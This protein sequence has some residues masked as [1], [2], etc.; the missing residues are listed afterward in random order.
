MLSITHPITIRAIIMEWWV[1]IRLKKRTAMIRRSKQLGKKEKEGSMT[2][3]MTARKKNTRIEKI[4]FM[5]EPSYLHPL[6]Y[7]FK[8][9]TSSIFS[10]STLVSMV[11]SWKRWDWSFVTISTRP[12]MSPFGK[13]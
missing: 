3:C 12:I 13:T 4:A 8:T 5:L 6:N 9:R 10:K 1:E 2:A 7:F 11:I